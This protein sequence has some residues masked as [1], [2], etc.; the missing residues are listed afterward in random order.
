M[1]FIKY[2]RKGRSSKPVIGI[3]RHG[4]ITINDMAL[5]KYFSGAK[6]VVMYYDPERAVIGLKPETKL[7]TETYHLRMQKTGGGAVISGRGFLRFFGIECS[8]ATRFEPRWNEEEKLVEVCMK[9]DE[10]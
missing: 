5:R 2:E 4:T 3:G 10:D 1:A 7:G 9:K 6:F 8:K